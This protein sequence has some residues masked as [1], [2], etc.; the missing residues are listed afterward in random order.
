MVGLATTILLEFPLCVTLFFLFEP[1]C[2]YIVHPPKEKVYRAALPNG[3][4]L[5]LPQPEAEI[6]GLAGGSGEKAGGL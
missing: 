2:T 5:L 4:A 3:E 1:F 6:L